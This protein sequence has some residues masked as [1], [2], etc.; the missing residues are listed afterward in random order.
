MIV[1]SLKLHGSLLPL[2]D[3]VATVW[4]EKLTIN[5]KNFRFKT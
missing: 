1:Y 4:E 3:S 5:Q 2:A